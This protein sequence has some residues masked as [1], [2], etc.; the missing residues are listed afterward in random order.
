[1]IRHPIEEVQE[2]FKENPNDFIADLTLCWDA[3]KGT[4]GT[5]EQVE[6]MLWPEWKP[7]RAIDVIIENYE[8]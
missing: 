4:I 2:I 6:N 5:R 8:K 3:G 7:K 1:M